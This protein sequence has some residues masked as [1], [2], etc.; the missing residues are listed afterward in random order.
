MIE[1][2]PDNKR[3]P[4]AFFV[5]GSALLALGD[6]DAARKALEELIAAHPSSDAAARAGTLLEQ[7]P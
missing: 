1:E 4:D 7:M 5:V 3:V 6:V 2:H